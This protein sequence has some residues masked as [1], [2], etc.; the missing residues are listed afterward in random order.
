MQWQ[1]EV[2]DG[3]LYR[4]SA[5]TAEPSPGHVQVK[6]ASASL[7]FRDVGILAGHYPCISPL[8][9]LSDGAGVVTALGAGV[10]GIAPGDRVM[11]NFYPY[12]YGGVASAENHR[13]SVGCDIHGMLRSHANLPAS[14]LH[15]IPHHLNMQEASTLPCAGVTAW[16]ALF[17]RGGLQPGEH[18][19]IQGTGG[20]AIFALQIA[21][22]A[23]AEVTVISSDDHKLER[24]KSL[25]ADHTLNYM[26]EPSWG[27][28]LNSRF[29]APA[30]DLVLELGGEQTMRESLSCLK[31]NGR[32]SVIGILSGAMASFSIVEMLFK[33]L[34]LSGVTVGSHQD[35][36][37]LVHF[38]ELHNIHPVVDSVFATDAA[39]ECYQAMV[40]AKHFGKLVVADS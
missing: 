35:V 32:V 15:R 11:S 40:G 1:Y 19:L 3:E 23:G 14:A 29:G 37:A 13:V 31:T 4:R 25:G 2:V 10:E 34:R 21:K 12:W 26:S 18:V 17:T 38:L 24:A 16:S 9:P 20:V 33:Q 6:V 22:A 36:G 39:Q 5:E 27:E 8:V 7:N 30:Y 28:A